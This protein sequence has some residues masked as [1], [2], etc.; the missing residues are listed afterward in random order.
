MA[1][2]SPRKKTA[3]RT[4]K[5]PAIAG[6]PPPRPKKKTA[7]KPAPKAGQDK[8]LRAVAHLAVAMDVFA[9][10][11]QRE[12]R[13]WIEEAPR[14]EPQRL[15]CSESMRLLAE[16]GDSVLVQYRDVRAVLATEAAT[17]A[18]PV[19]D[20]AAAAYEIAEWVD[21]EA[22]LERLVQ[23]LWSVA[24]RM[25]VPYTAETQK[26]MAD[27][28]RKMNMLAQTVSEVATA[29]QHRCRSDHPRQGLSPAMTNA[30]A[31]LKDQVRLA[32]SDMASGLADTAG[33]GPEITLRVESA[34]ERAENLAGIASTL[35]DPLK[36]FVMQH[37][38][39]IRAR[40]LSLANDI[41]Y[42]LENVNFLFASAKDLVEYVGR[43]LDAA[44]TLDP[45]IEEDCREL[46]RAVRS[47]RDEHEALQTMIS[48][49]REI[50]ARAPYRHFSRRRPLPEW[51][52]LAEEDRSVVS[53]LVR[54]RHGDPDEEYS[55]ANLATVQAALGH[56]ADGASS[57]RVRRRLQYLEAEFEITGSCSVNRKEQKQGGMYFWI[58]EDAFQRYGEHV[59]GKSRGSR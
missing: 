37:L 44:R 53:A 48:R 11:V 8:R 3:G 23:T 39:E 50:V 46:D 43:H 24:G 32:L 30:L 22:V 27:D 21:C 40:D 9:D 20:V 29:L 15:N 42:L 25:D 31:S 34:I 10:D 1:S 38:K 58:N 59:L 13:K 41:D 7:G 17:S 28:L 5:K 47:M 12:Y 14:T 57:Q 6:P 16:R 36:V 33:T 45:Q 55:V 19:A 18:G 2:R 56:V 54:L 4:A 52:D 49:Y 35:R 51:N 26:K